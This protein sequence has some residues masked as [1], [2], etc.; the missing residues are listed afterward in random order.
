MTHKNAKSDNLKGT[1]ALST[2][3]EEFTGCII[4]FISYIKYWEKAILLKIL[5]KTVLLG[6][7]SS[8]ILKHLKA[9]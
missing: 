3:A 8:P 7:P 5:W 9:R 4:F 2:F 6:Q 1:F